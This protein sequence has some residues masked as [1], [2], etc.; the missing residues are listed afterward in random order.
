VSRFWGPL[1]IFWVSQVTVEAKAFRGDEGRWLGFPSPFRSSAPEPG[2]LVTGTHQVPSVSQIETGPPE[3]FWMDVG[4]IS[5]VPPY[6]GT[7]N[8]ESL[9]AT[10]E[11]V[12]NVNWSVS[13]STS[14]NLTRPKIEGITFE[15]TSWETYGQLSLGFTGSGP[16]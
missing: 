14:Q 4:K 12:F 15:G 13:I 6:V 11:S 3:G 7:T 5:V 10:S 9:V 2:F 16:S 1:Y 8:R